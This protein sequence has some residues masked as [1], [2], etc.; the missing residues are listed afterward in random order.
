MAPPMQ[1]KVPFAPTHVR[2]VEGDRVGELAALLSLAPIFII[3]AYATL[4]VSRRELHV[5]FV[6][7]GQLANVRLNAALKAAIGEPRPSGA[8]RTDAG[9]PSDHAQF[10]GFWATYICAFLAVRVRFAHRAGWRP[11]LGAAVALLAVLVATSRVYLGEHSAAQ[12]AVGGC[13]GALIGACWYALY[14]AAVRP[15]VVALL[16][17]PLLE[18]FYVRDC[19]HLSDVV[20]WEHAA[21]AAARA[22][23]VGRRT[24]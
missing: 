10:M 17:A 2:F 14:E 21:I 24:R 5:G 19:S 18:Y 15:N 3:V 12:V 6:L 1:P 9:M 20:S 4:I 8:E 16:R 7:V 13:I 22:E 11:L 23:S